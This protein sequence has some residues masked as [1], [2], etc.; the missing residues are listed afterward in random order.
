MSTPY[1][2]KNMKIKLRKL[3]RE[4]IEDEEIPGFGRPEEEITGK[5]KYSFTGKKSGILKQIVA[6]RS[7]GNVRKGNVGGWIEGEK[8]LSQEGECWVS[9]NAKVSGNARVYGD[10]LVYGNARVSEDAWVF[11]DA[12]V[13]GNAKVAGNAQVY[14][15]AK[16][17]G[18]AWVFEDTWVCGNASVYGNAK[19]AGNAKV[20]GDAW[21]YGNAK[22]A[23][24]ASAYGNAKVYG[25]AW[26]SGNAQVAGDAQVSGRAKVSGDAEVS[27]RAKVSGDM[28]IKSGTHLARDELARSVHFSRAIREALSGFA[29]YR[30]LVDFNDPK[31]LEYFEGATPGTDEIQIVL[32]ALDHL[33]ALQQPIAFTGALDYAYSCDLNK[34]ILKWTASDGSVVN[35]K[36]FTDL[37]KYVGDSWLDQLFQNTYDPLESG[38]IVESKSFE[39]E[40]YEGR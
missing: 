40:E 27:G 4:A 1:K 39:Q 17:Y 29:R 35:L 24:N 10:A 25:D 14:E 21:V 2:E 18:D 13:N 38:N 16:V 28:M 26:V 30:E 11:E 15:N 5:K 22:V 6:L 37:H 31:V 32:D 8:N 19:V 7:F 12:Q 34:N 23:E 9:G 33:K 36:S 3:I 20:Y